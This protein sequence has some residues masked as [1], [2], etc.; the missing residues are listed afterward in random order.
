MTAASLAT[1]RNPLEVLSVGPAAPLQA[2][3]GLE[4]GPEP[5]AGRLAEKPHPDLA[6]GRLAGLDDFVRQGP[7][8]QRLGRPDQGRV[9][10]ELLRDAGVEIVL[11]QG[12]G[13]H[14]ILLGLGAEVLDE[15]LVGI[16]GQAPGDAAPAADGQRDPGRPIPVQPF[17][18]GLDPGPALGRFEKALDALLGVPGDGQLLQALLPGVEKSEDIPVPDVGAGRGD[19][20]GQRVLVEFLADD[21]PRADP[22]PPQEGQDHLV[23]LPEPAFADLELLVPGEQPDRA[24][25][26]GGGRSG[27][28]DGRE[29]GGT[30]QGDE[31]R[32]TAREPACHDRASAQS[33][34]SCL[35]RPSLTASAMIFCWMCE[36]ASS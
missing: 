22:V 9:V 33:S 23:P 25:R 31:E 26:Q 32:D 19:V 17:L 1:V 10:L 24:G 3:V 4:P 13:A 12:G 5:E 15:P 16:V 18:Q 36:G 21:D 27:Q 11:D 29:S 8:G 7:A 6:D 28:G 35:T 20:L 34:S 30:G 2:Q 14:E